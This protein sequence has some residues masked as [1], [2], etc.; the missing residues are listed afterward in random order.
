VASAALGGHRRCVRIQIPGV[1]EMVTYSL[2]SELAG[3]AAGG[4]A[5]AAATA[6]STV[7]VRLVSAKE[8]W[9]SS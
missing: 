9:M 1:M 7:S 2:G 3:A 4:G 5:N 8:A 6:L